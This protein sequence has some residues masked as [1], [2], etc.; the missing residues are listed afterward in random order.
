[1]EKYSLKN[2]EKLIKELSKSSDIEFHNWFDTASSVEETIVRGYWDFSFNILKPKVCSYIDIPHEKHVLEIGYGGG[3]LLNAACSY[4]KFSIGIDIHDESFK[5]TDFLHKQGKKNFK[6]IK[7]D[8]KTIDYDSDSVDLIYSFI[9]LV[10]MD[11][12]E[13]IICYLNE[14][15]RVIKK[16]GIAQLF[17]GGFRYA[18]R[19]GLKSYIKGYHLTLP[20]KGGR[21]TGL[22]R[23]T[24]HEY[25][26]KKLAR[27]AGFKI[28]AVGDAYR[29]VPEGYPNK[30]GVQRYITLL[31]P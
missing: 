16:G 12:I 29:Q 2:V 4:F 27:R 26:M 15:F 22:P 17:Y 1:M 18:R 14:T 31:K 25:Y 11:S 21:W 7:T 9:V 19:I 23:F 20:V 30:L 24:L 10:H 28:V 8:G 13:K 5:V 3:R 6:L